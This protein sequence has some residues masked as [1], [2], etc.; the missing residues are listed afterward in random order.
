[1]DSDGFR[2]A[3]PGLSGE[4]AGPFQYPGERTDEQLAA[5][6]HEGLTD[7]QRRE[8]L[9]AIIRQGNDLL[10]NLH[11]AWEACA[12]VVNRDF[13][14]ETEAREWLGR[15]VGVWE[16]ELGKLNGPKPS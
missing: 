13:R 2:K 3:Y 12:D 1:M 5:D 16:R 6:I 10:L 7:E 14:D 9:S 11:D 8:V 15:V 4:F